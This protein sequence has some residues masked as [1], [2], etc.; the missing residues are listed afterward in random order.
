MFGSIGKIEA[1]DEENMSGIGD[2]WF[3]SGVFRAG[4]GQ[5]KVGDEGRAK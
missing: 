5:V 4:Q 1:R 3:T 2:I